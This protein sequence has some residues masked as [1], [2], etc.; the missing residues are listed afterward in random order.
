MLNRVKVIQTI[1]D[2]IKAKT[3]LEIGVEGGHTFLRINAREKIAVDPEFKIRR[4][5]R[6]KHIFKNPSNLFN[7]YHQ[8]ESDTFFETKSNKLARR[9]VDV[10]LID[11][12]HTY[13][14]SLRDAQNTL[15]FLN[16]KGIIVMHDCNP[17]CKTAAY[18][19]SSFKQAESLNLDEWTGQW[20]GD[21]WKTVCYLRSTQK[22]LRIFVLDCDCGLGIITRGTPENILSYSEQDINNLTYNNLNEDRTEILNLKGP[23][24]FGEFIKSI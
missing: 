22:N 14:Q 11:G 24:F 12:L 2:R 7:T 20:Y 23:D 10:A 5:K 1:I 17:P 13:E 16:Q 3:Y 4:K 8:M 9:G 19:A 6:F 21:V 15:K 18:P